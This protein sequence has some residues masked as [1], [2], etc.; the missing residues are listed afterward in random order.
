MCTIHNI[1][2]LNLIFAFIKA[3]FALYV[4]GAGITLAEDMLIQQSFGVAFHSMG[5]GLAML[6]LMSGFIIPVHMFSVKRHNKFLLIVAFI[7]DLLVMSLVIKVGLDIGTYT[8]PSYSKELQLDCNRKVP[9]IYN[10]SE[11]I[12]YYEDE[13]T[14]GYRLA[15]TALYN[16]RN[17]TNSFQILTTLEGRKCCGFFGPSN[18]IPDIKKFPSDRPQLGIQ[19]SQLKQRVT[20]GNKPTY[21]VTQRDCLDYYD[22]AAIPPIVG[23]CNFDMGLGFCISQKITDRSSGC[24][25][26]MQDYMISLISPH[27][28]MLI[29][30]SALNIL[31][32]FI[33]CCMFWKRKE[34]DVF[35][36]FTITKVKVN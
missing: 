26:E 29:A 18:C 25:F 32:M 23:G 22:P 36:E 3:I 1:R 5:A 35:P 27:A 9:Q 13:N 2:L 7:V 34:Y 12:L 24:A 19:K 16:D 17:N 31:S 33:A 14:A 10:K 8:I 30:S 11:C 6:G 4:F 15:W 21:Y 28:V 20:C